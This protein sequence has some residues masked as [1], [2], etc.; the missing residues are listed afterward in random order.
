[1]N[2][3]RENPSPLAGE[4]AARRRCGADEGAQSLT[5][6]ARS[7]RSRMTDAERKLWFALKGRRFDAFKFRRQV[8]TGPYIADFPCFES[9]LIVEV[10]GGQHAESAR[11]AERDAW[12]GQNSFRVV[13]YL[14]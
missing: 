10:D 9:R 2:S 1:M 4:G 12:L 11:D 13:R 14:E 3:R 8:P 5:K 7:L 6:A